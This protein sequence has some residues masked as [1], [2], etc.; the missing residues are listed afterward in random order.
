MHGLT[1]DYIHITVYP[2]T[3]IIVLSLLQI[4]KASAPYLLKFT[5]YLITCSRSVFKIVIP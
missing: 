2:H 5:V 3:L 1:Y 4:E